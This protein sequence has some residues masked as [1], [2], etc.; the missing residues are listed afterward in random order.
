MK[1]SVF[2]LEVVDDLLISFGTAGPISDRDWTAYIVH[3]KMP[4]IKRYIG[5]SLGATEANSVQRKEVAATIKARGIPVVVVTDA[6]FVRGLVTAISWLGVAKI[7]A[8]DWPELGKGLDQL[9]VT[10]AQ[11]ENASAIIRRLK[12]AH[13]R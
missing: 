1:E 9:G 11:H 10:G 4:T 8:F 6:N 3:L 2:K 5:A 7:K 12:A 13:V